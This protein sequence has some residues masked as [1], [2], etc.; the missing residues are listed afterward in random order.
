[1]LEL[2]KIPVQRKNKNSLEIECKVAELDGIDFHRTSTETRSVLQIRLQKIKWLLLWCYFTRK[3][4][5]K[6]FISRRIKLVKLM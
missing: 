5:D 6:T 1:M 4:I 2:S 3:V